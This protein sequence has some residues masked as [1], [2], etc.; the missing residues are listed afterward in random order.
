MESEAQNDIV[1]NEKISPAIA[2]LDIVS[3]NITSDLHLM[4]NVSSDIE[5]ITVDFL[6]KN[7]SDITNHTTISSIALTENSTESPIKE[8]TTARIMRSRSI[9]LFS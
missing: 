7:E 1:T 9:S 6:L 5:N 2:T 8:S 4:Q 3:D